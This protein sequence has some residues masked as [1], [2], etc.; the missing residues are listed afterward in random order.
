MVTQTELIKGGVTVTLGS[1]Q[2]FLLKLKWGA[3]SMWRKRVNEFISRLPVYADMVS[4]LSP[5][6][7]LSNRKAIKEIGEEQDG[8]PPKTVEANLSKIL[9]QG[10]AYLTLYPE[11]LLDFIRLYAPELS[12]AENIADM[13]ENGDTDQVVVA[14]TEVMKMSYPFF[15]ELV[16]LLKLK[17]GL[18]L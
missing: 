3:A 18:K 7:I 13:D 2:H 12:S 5:Q 6:D 11:T 17:T 16:S 8:N 9:Q 4:T 15:K 1:K 10:I 14:F